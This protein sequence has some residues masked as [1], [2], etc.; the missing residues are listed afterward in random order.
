MYG[1]GFICFVHAFIWCIDMMCC[2]VLTMFSDMG[3]CVCECFID[4]STKM[5]FYF[6]NEMRK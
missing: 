2:Y 3:I 6:L 4:I 1:Y 5:D